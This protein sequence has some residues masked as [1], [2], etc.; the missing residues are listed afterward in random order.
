MPIIK[1]IPIHQSPKRLIRY[2]LNSGKTNDLKYASGFNVPVDD[3][4]A[5]YHMIC[6]TCLMSLRTWARS[7][8]LKRYLPLAESLKY[9]QS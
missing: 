9:L 1:Y 7:R 3:V 6:D 2:V 8:S 5:C 4:E